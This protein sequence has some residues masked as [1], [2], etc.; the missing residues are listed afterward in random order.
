[1]TGSFALFDTPIGRCAIVW[2]AAGIAGLQLPEADDAALRAAVERKH[3]G[4][5]EATPPTRVAAAIA[6]LRRLLAG[7]AELLSDIPLDLEGIPPFHRAVYAE[8]RR[9][10]PGQTRS[11]GQL[12]QALGKPGAARAVGQ[13]LGANP[14]ALIVPCHRVLA[15]DGRLNGF[16]A[17]G[18]V[19]TKRR[20]LAIESG[21]DRLF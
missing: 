16:S 14:F 15:A 17:H 3:P 6:A 19:E 20:L 2:T 11:Y 21:A 12:A 5:R 1:M 8:A 13:A 7:E 9:I 10:P 4:S 18:G